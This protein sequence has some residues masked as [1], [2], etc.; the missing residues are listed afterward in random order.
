MVAAIG[1]DN[2]LRGFALEDGRPVLTA[3]GV[4]IRSARPLPRRAG[5]C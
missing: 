2:D 4:T 5:I 1:K 3:A